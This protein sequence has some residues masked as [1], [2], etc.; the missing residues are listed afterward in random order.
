M[1][2]FSETI[3]CTLSSDTAIRTAAEETYTK[4]KEN[5]P[6]D[7]V[8][9]LIQNLSD[10]QLDEVVRGQSAILLRQLMKKADLEE[11]YYA[12]LGAQGQTEIRTKLLELFEAEQ[13]P[14]L[15]KKVADAVQ[16]FANAVCNSTE[17]AT[18]TLGYPELLPAMLRTVCNSAADSSLRADSLWI[19][20]E[21]ATSTSDVLL[22]AGQVETTVQTIRGCMSDQQN[23]VISSGGVRLLLSV[24]DVADDNQRAPLLPLLREVVPVI[25]RICNESDA[26]FLNDVLEELVNSTN[27]AP[28]V[29]PLLETGIMQLLVAVA[30]SHPDEGCRKLALEGV[31]V[32]A[33]TKPKTLSNTAQYFEQTLDLCTNFMMT[34]TDDASWATSTDEDDEEEEFLIMGCN[35]VDRLGKAMVKAKMFDKLLK[36]IET[37]VTTLFKSGDWKQVLACLAIMCQIAEYVDDEATAG[38]MFTAAL[39]QVRAAHPRVR[40]GAWTC[41]GRFAED[42]TK[43][44]TSEEFSSKVLTELVAGMSDSCERVALRAMDAFKDYGVEADRDDLESFVPQIMEEA[45]K[46]LQGN[47]ECQKSSI[48]TISVVAAQMEDGFAAY[49]TKLMPLLETVIGSTIHKAEERVLLGKC[50]ECI[51]HLAKAGGREQFKADMEK[52]MG[53]MIQAT[54]VPNLPKDDPIKEYMMAASQRICSVMKEDFLVFLPHIINDVLAAFALAPRECSPEQLE[55]IEADQQRVA[56]EVEN[57]KVRVLVINTTEMEELY[58]ALLCVLTFV[59]ELKKMYAPFVEQTATALLPV[60]EFSMEET[61]RDCA[62]N[63]WGQLVACARDAGSADVVSK[64]VHIFL[65]KIV[66]K[67]TSESASDETVKT[68]ADGVTTCL[69]SAGCSVLTAANVQ[70]VTSTIM[71]MLTER[72]LVNEAPDPDADEG[73]DEDD[74]DPNVVRTSLCE[75]VGSVMRHHPDMFMTEGLPVCMPIVQELLKPGVDREKRVLAHYI[76]CDFLEHLGERITPQWPSFLQ[77]LLTDLNSS[78]ASLRQVSCYAAS[79]AARSASFANA[80]PDTAQKLVAIVADARARSKKKSE[81]PAQACA[82]NALTALAVILENHSACLGAA[83]PQLWNSWRVGLPCQEDVQEGIANHKRLAQMLQQEKPEI[84]G[85]GSANVPSIVGLLVDQHKSDFVDDETNQ[86]IGSI[87]LKLGEGWFQANASQF[88]AKQQKKIFRIM[89]EAKQQ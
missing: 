23:A 58:N 69:K 56:I 62:F 80:C 32:L 34:V 71:K 67:L 50:F 3:R 44:V 4:L 86:L 33:E 10:A 77:E 28:L 21:V 38:Q 19:M 81:Q 1:S 12:K 51:S 43:L 74:E 48:T 39:A 55:A 35:A 73:V 52:F 59:G 41:V 20:K 45:G 83:V 65:E 29:K 61:I 14:T 79:L 68:C 24:S 75:V 53:L 5:S 11:G 9:A 22:A 89:Q 31:L 26:Q 16:T 47:V 88:S 25:Q 42:H 13:V 37:A 46:K 84:V 30:K 63:V 76:T 72:Y 54:K 60:F 85:A 78:E 70:H 36:V 87:A 57:E 82:D 7:T 6:G 40:Y 15:R 18:I 64:L 2:T 49:Y 66:A 17:A 27:F 8:V